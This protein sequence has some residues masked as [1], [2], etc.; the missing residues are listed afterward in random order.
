MSEVR[1]I[2]AGSGIAIPPHQVDNHML[3]RIIETNDD[4]VRER[5]G[6]VTRYYVD[7]G[8]GSAGA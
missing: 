8:V 5:S 7:A 4:W 1:A 3:S 6:I 2:F